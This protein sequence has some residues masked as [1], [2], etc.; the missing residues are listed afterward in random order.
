MTMAIKLET[1][2]TDAK[3]QAAV[4]KFMQGEHNDENFLFY[5][6]KGNNEA[7]YKKYIQKSAAKQVNLPTTVTNPLDALA[8]IKN[9][10]GMTPGIAAA[11]TAILRLVNNDAMPR[12]EKSPEYAAYLAAKKP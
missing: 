11:K 1:T 6:D 4:L 9:W 8:S 3:L 7:L 12:F 5:F 10:N 2:K